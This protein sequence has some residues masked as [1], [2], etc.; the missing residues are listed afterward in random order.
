MKVP[1]R[2]NPSKT[3]RLGNP[4]D[5]QRTT[6]TKG[7]PGARMNNWYGKQAQPEPVGASQM[8][9]RLGARLGGYTQ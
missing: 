7:D 4:Y 5:P 6:L 2:K 1:K 9:R 8:L 3:E